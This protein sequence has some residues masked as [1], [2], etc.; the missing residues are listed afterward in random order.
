MTTAPFRCGTRAVLTMIGSYLVAVLAGYAGESTNRVRVIRVP[1]PG[2]VMKAQLGAN[3]TIHLLL[4][5]PDG[6]QYVKSHD[7]G[8][9]FSAPMAVVDS[10]LRKPGLKF[11]G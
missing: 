11:S 3:G 5:A 8:R 7:A 6:P 1:V 2:A 10:A 4:D 9:T